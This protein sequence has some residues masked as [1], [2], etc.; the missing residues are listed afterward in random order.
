MKFFKRRIAGKEDRY[1]RCVISV[2]PMA[3]WATPKRSSVL[4]ALRKVAMDFA[5]VE[6]E[7]LTTLLQVYLPYGKY[8]KNFENPLQHLVEEFP[9]IVPDVDSRSVFAYRD[10]D[11]R[12]ECIHGIGICPNCSRAGRHRPLA[13]YDGEADP[14]F[15]CS[16]CGVS[17]RASEMKFVVHSQLPLKEVI[18]YEREYEKAR[19]QPQPTATSAS[20]T[21]TE[22]IRAR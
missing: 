11:D 7:E 2:Y 13:L 15:R 1:S 3:E 20:S 6:H 16:Y 9:G 18:K 10:E 21:H 22:Y 12:W 5:I 8:S 19:Q 17:H 14:V 4:R